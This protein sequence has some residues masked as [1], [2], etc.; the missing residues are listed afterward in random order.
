MGEGICEL[1]KSNCYQ[2]EVYEDIG[3]QGVDSKDQVKHDERS[4]KLLQRGCDSKY[5]RLTVTDWH[6]DM[7]WNT[8][9]KLETSTHKS[10]KPATGK[11]PATSGRGDVTQGKPLPI[12]LLVQGITAGKTHRDLRTQ[13]R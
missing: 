6:C 5:N 7:I 8:Q 3:L 11:N 2:N 12:T 4:D 10:A 9:T 1:A 13:Q